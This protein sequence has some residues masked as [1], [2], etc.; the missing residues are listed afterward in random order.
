LKGAVADFPGPVH[1]VVMDVSKPEDWQRAQAEAEKKFGPVDI[2]VNCAAI[3]PKQVPILDVDIDFFDRLLAVNLKGVF[4]G[5]KTFGTGMR[6]RKYGHI[7][8]IASHAGLF[9]HPAIGEYVAAKYGVVGITETARM[10]L[11]PFGV[12]VGVCTPG[13]VRSNMTVGMGM[14][15]IW[16]GR[17]ILKGIE[18][19]KPFIITHPNCR[20]PIEARHRSLMSCIGDWAQPGFSEKLWKKDG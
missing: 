9:G 3:P 2:L 17:A 6:A 4:Y 7:L 16:I 12:G 8:N 1:G 13:L 20:E 15:P 10:E 18:E 11:E 14:E 19:N 5:M